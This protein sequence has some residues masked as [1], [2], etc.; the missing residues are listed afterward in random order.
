MFTYREKRRRL[1]DITHGIGK[2]KSCVGKLQCYPVMVW[3]HDVLS[4]DGNVQ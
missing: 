1:C 4:G 2:I 3:S